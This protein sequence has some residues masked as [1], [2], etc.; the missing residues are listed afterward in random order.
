MQLPPVHSVSLSEYFVSGNVIIHE[1]AV[2]APGV[3]LEAAPDCQITI[4]AGVC[5]GL[6]SV[7]SAHAGDVKIQEQTAIAP[8]CLVIGPVTIGATACLGS[9]STVFQQDIDAQ[10][11]IPPGSLLMN[12]VADVQT[13]GASSP[14]TDSVTEKKSP[15]TANPIAPIPSPWDNEPPAKGTDSPSDQAK[16]SIARQS[17]PSTAE[18]AEQISSNRSPGESTPTAPTVV[19]TAP[20]VSEEVQ[21]KPPVVGQVYIN[22]LLL[23]LFPE[24][25]YFS[26]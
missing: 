22:Q 2:I 26:S 14:T 6:G 4:E 25:R 15:S 24:R 3:I 1:T 8:G 7:I 20:L 23:T 5:I 17:R 16:E 12:R 21:E 10:V 18:A 13:V 19:T 11:L 9:R